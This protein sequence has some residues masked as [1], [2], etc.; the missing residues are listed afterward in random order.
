MSSVS[1][2]F[3]KHLGHLY[4]H[5]DATKGHLRDILIRQARDVL[6]C[7]FHGDLTAFERTFMA[8]AADIIVNIKKRHFGN[9]AVSVEQKKIIENETWKKSC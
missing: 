8:P 1:S 3:D 9:E 2:L 5:C 4:L 7:T 6:V